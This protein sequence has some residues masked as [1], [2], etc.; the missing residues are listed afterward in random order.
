MSCLGFI[1]LQ[2][3]KPSGQHQS[4]RFYVV[5]V[6]GNVILGLPSCKKPTCNILDPESTTFGVSN[7]EVNR[8]CTTRSMA[9]ESFQLNNIE[10]VKWY[11]PV[12]FDAIGKLHGDT[13]LSLK[14][15]SPPYIDAPCRTPVHLLPKIKSQLNKMVSDRIIRKVEQQTDW[16]SSATYVNTKDVTIRI[17]LDPQKLNLALKRC[18]HKI[19]TV[20]EINP[21]LGNE[22]YFS[23]L[24]V[25]A[26]YWNVKLVKDS[27]EWPTFRTPFGRYCYLRMPI[28]LSVSQDIFQQHMGCIIDQCDSVRS[29]RDDI[30]VY[31][32]TEEKHD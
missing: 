15:D 11:F 2:L 32:A 21:Q 6:P 28:R 5:D 4:H 17:C 14:P 20:N 25:K 24:D 19:P 29:I 18:P 22:K 27:T 23:K 9:P 8:L 1:V 3:S 31:C 10:D 16:C 7:P 26:G 30:I 13:K 12:C